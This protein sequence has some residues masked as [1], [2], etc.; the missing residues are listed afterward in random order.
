MNKKI[1]PIPIRPTWNDG[2][3]K[4]LA[5]VLGQIIYD[6]CDGDVPLYECT[7]DALKFLREGYH[8]YDDGYSMAKE[9]EYYGYNPDSD[10]VESLSC[11]WYEREKILDKHICQWV[12]E[13]ALRLNLEIGQSVDIFANDKLRPDNV[14]CE[15][16]SLYHDKFQYGVWHNA[17][18]YEKGKGH[19]IVDAE[20]VVKV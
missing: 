6:W 15:I 17:L 2:M 8:F 3:K 16:V 5:V 9:F 19:V 1:S 14:K 11:L 12:K 10:L 4:E 7:E 13:N 20:E 18:K